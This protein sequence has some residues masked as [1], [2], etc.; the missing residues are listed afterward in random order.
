MKKSHNFILVLQV[1][2]SFLALVDL[3]DGKADTIVAALRQFMTDNQLP[4]H[5]FIGLGSDGASVMVGRKTGV[6]I[7][8]VYNALI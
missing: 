2:T 1:Q 5:C 4:A 8:Y 6:S 7:K 3:P